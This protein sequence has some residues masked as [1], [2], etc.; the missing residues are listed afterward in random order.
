MRYFRVFWLDADGKHH[1]SD[2]ISDWVSAELF[3][4]ELRNDTAHIERF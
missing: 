3:R 2:P 1:I 4:R